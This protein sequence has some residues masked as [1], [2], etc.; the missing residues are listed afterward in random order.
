MEQK[1][2]VKILLKE[3]WLS[4]TLCAVQQDA[5]AVSLAQ[6]LYWC[7]DWCLIK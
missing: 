1:T 6:E 4:G 3:V 7:I 2:C 5:N